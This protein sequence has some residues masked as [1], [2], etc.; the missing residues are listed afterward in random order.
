MSALPHS[1]LVTELR[2]AKYATKTLQ[3]DAA[4]AIEALS[5]KVAELEAF[6]RFVHDQLELNGAPL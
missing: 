4:D 3:M 1:E 2:E 5:T 6:I